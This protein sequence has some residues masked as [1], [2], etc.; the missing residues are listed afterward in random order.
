MGIVGPPVTTSAAAS[1]GTPGPTGAALRPQA[2][3]LPAGVALRYETTWITATGE[4]LPGA[5]SAPIT[6]LAPTKPTFEVG[7]DVGPIPYPTVAS[8]GGLS[9][10]ATY[11][12]WV[13]FISGGW[14]SALSSI[15]PGGYA[16]GTPVGTG[17]T[18]NWFWGFM[19]S[20]D[21]RVT[22]RKIYRSS[23]GGLTPRLLAT[24]TYNDPAA[25][26]DRAFVDT[27]ADAS[28]GPARVGSGAIGTPPGSQALVTL[29]PASAPGLTARALYRSDAG[30]PFRH[31]VTISNLAATEYLD[32]AASVT[33]AT[34]PTVDTTGGARWCL[35][36]LATIATGPPAVTARRLYRT[37]ANSVPSA[38]SVFRLV[39]TLGDNTTTTATDATPDAGLGGPM[40]AA[41]STLVQQVAL[42]QIP[43]GGPGTTA[44]RLY[45]SSANTTALKFLTAI[46]NNTTTTA[47]DAA[48]DATL[49]AAAPVSDTSGLTQPAGLVA[50]GATVIPVAGPSAFAPTGGY[51]VVGNGEQVVRYTGV[52]GNTLIGIPASGPGSLTATV[53]YNASITVAP[54]LLGIPASGPWAIVRGLID[55]E[56]INL[57]I[58]RDDLAAQAALAA[59][60]GGDGVIEHVIIDRRLSAAGATVTAAAELALF[61]TPEL[62]VSYTTRDPRTRTGK[63]VAINLPAPTNVVGSFLIQRVQLSRFH[64]PN[65]PPLR[66]VQASSTRFS[67]DDVLRRLSFEVSA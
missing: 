22:G 14:E 43:I 35:V 64:I 2:G 38:A 39:A 47:T 53:A 26:H 24:L 44:R 52:S 45:R 62:R 1:V 58:Q 67:F 13:S 41:N 5:A 49:G 42:S 55:G 32:S 30:A 54:T 40:P 17:A 51:A 19:R 12:Y 34:A 60:E 20:T 9:S 23:A 21:A 28:L 37:P 65:L 18:V 33:G 16:V 31:L 4:T 63:L 36:P 8:G 66:T 56:D 15:P 3:N 61:S 6:A 27:T 57:I 25:T 59:I 50:A 10:A 11:L 48:S 29:A 46:A 7:N